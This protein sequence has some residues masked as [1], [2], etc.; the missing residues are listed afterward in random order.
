MRV[1]ALW[2]IVEV[3]EKLANFCAGEN[4]GEGAEM[5]E[6]WIGKEA[7]TP[8]LSLAGLP[9]ARR[10]INRRTITFRNYITFLTVKVLRVVLGG[11]NNEG[12]EDTEHCLAKGVCQNPC[13]SPPPKSERSPRLAWSSSKP[14]C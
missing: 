9:V 12:L 5:L 11:T 3:R 10:S 6:G 13:P 2:A 1:E 4:Q 8:L 14:W 7:G